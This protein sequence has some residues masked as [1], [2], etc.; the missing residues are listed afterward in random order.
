MP[1]KLLLAVVAGMAGFNSLAIAIRRVPTEWV[2][3][4]DGA[5][6]V[7][8]GVTLCL[9]LSARARMR[10]EAVSLVRLPCPVC[11]YPLIAAGT[12]SVRCPECGFLGS[13]ELTQNSWNEYLGTR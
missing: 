13:R 8:L 4:T 1:Q 5:L 2:L 9:A 7:L 12:E 6:L 11:R 10:R 3:W